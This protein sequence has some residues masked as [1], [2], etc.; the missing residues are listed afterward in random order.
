MDH[1]TSVP[2]LGAGPGCVGLEEEGSD[3]TVSSPVAPTGSIRALPPRSS[4]TEVIAP[5]SPRRRPRA[6]PTAVLDRAESPEEESAGL[7]WAGSSARRSL[8]AT[9][10][11]QIGPPTPSQP[12]VSRKPRQLAL[13]GSLMS[14]RSMSEHSIPCPECPESPSPAREDFKT[15]PRGIAVVFFDFDGTLTATPGD[16]AARRTKQVE[17]CERAAMLEPR[18]RGLRADGASLGI[19]SKSTEGTIRSALEASGL[20]KFF[21]APLVAKAV[22]FEGKAG[23]IED[24]ALKGCLPR[25]G[26]TRGHGVPFS[27]ILLVDDDVLELERAKARGLQVY[28]APADGGLQEEDFDIISEALHVPRPR[29]HPQRATMTPQRLVMAPPLVMRTPSSAPSFGCRRS[30]VR[31]HGRKSFKEDQPLRLPSFN[32]FG[33]GGRWRNVILFSGDCFEG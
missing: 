29:S 23:F 14:L 9:E 12:S 27:R 25:L 15:P 3:S 21:D 5:I 4:V 18:L 7:P 8:R 24:L 2:N 13:S 1:C 10:E 17:L 22:G 33:R 26:S 28:A 19:I 11:P 31:R 20:L 32:D 6:R 30:S 16:R